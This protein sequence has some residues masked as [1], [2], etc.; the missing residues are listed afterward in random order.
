VMTLGAGSPPFHLP[1]CSPAALPIH[2]ILPT[3][4]LSLAL[5]KLRGIEIDRFIHTSKV[6]A[7][8]EAKNYSVL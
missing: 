1:E 8:K 2:V 4:M 6:T 3:Q 5:A 7:T